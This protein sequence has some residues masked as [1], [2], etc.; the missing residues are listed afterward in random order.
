MSIL[1]SFGGAEA[2][3]GRLPRPSGSQLKLVNLQVKATD[4]ALR[5]VS[6]IQVHNLECKDLLVDN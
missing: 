3:Q 1:C 6:F 4:L 5:F 2:C